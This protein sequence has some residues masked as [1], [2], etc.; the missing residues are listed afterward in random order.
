MKFVSNLDLAKNELQNARLQNLASAPS[1]PVEGQIY[2][3]TVAKKLYYYNGTG[4]VNTDVAGVVPTSRTINGKPLSADVVLVAS[5]ISGFG[6]VV[7]KDIAVSGNASASQVVMGNDTRLADARTPLTHS[8]TKS[9]ITD[10]GTVYVYKGTVET[11][12]ALSDIST[13]V[14][15][16]IYN[17]TENGMNYAWDGSAW[18]ALGGTIDI[19]GKEDIANKTTSLSSSSTDAQYPS[20]KSVYDAL[21]SITPTGMVHKFTKTLDTASS[22]YSVIHNLGTTDVIVQV[23]E[24]AT[25][26]GVI[27]DWNCVDTNT[28]QISFAK[29]QTANAYKVVIV[30]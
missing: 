10:L 22:A 7:T 1:N 16:D 4:W 11:V 27:V 15:G 24:I 8:H 28:I 2:Y 29:A 9:D 14:T 25:N 23:I 19:S 18:D 13:K 17:V 12:A 6:T 5:D 20:A 30:G 21:Q 26:S 3:D